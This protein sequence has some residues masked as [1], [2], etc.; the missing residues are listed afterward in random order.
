MILINS[1]FKVIQTFGLMDDKDFTENIN[2]AKNQ[3]SAIFE[4]GTKEA[5]DA[6][7]K[8]LD[9]LQSKIKRLED[10]WMIAVAIACALVPIIR[11]VGSYM[12]P[13][14]EGIEEFEHLRRN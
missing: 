7:Y 12:L 4:D 2:K 8:G 9:L 6:K 10:N 11:W 14:K 13:E 3:Y 5:K 1:V